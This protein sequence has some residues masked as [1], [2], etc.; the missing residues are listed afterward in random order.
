M[1]ERAPPPLWWTGDLVGCMEDVCW[2]LRNG[3]WKEDEV[4]EMMMMDGGD[5]RDRMV[6]R[7]LE[8]V[9]C[10]VRVLSL[11]LL[12]AGWSTEDVVDSLG[13]RVEYDVESWL[14]FQ[15]TKSCLL[16]AI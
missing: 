4:R 9:V 3:G 10:H 5:E 15:H 16:E 2:R 6:S 14:D 1:M 13:Y 8:G 11:R 12:R 7:D